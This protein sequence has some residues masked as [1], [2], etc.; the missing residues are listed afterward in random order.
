[1]DEKTPA[2]RTDEHYEETT[3]PRNP[4]ESML[5]PTARTGWLLSSLGTIAVMFLVV[6]AAFGWVYVRHELGS[7]QQIYPD[8]KA[9]G[10][11]GEQQ[12]REGTPGGFNP[13]DGAF[14]NTREEL[15]FRGAAD[16]TEPANGAI[17]S[18]SD[19]KNAPVGSRI[20]L[21]GLTVDRTEGSMFWVRAGEG[22]ILV[23]VPGDV[24]TVKA[25]QR[26]DVTGTVESVSGGAGIRAT[27]ISVR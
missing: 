12:P 13:S 23:T 19:F 7:Q 11:S 9:T 14:S 22:S 18:V 6:A 5:R 1:M 21:S 25:G 2:T 24:P 15:K 4:P 3:N 16:S 20:S 26:V 27:R 17:T 8:P 10:T